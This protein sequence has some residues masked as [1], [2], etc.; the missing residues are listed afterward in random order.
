[1]E[2]EQNK[3]TEGACRRRCSTPGL[4]G[5]PQLLWPPEYQLWHRED[6]IQGEKASFLQP[7]L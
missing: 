5:N 2:A 1:M 7:D 6:V 3:H 4:E